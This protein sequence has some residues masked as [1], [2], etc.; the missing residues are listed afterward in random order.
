M[1]KFQYS[2]TKEVVKLGDLSV[3]A[4]EQDAVPQWAGI[5]AIVVGGALF[6]GGLLKK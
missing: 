3:K 6:A 2:H 5:V 4:Q 1:G